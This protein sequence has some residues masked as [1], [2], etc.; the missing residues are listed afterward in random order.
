MKFSTWKASKAASNSSKDRA[1]SSIES[2][3]DPPTGNNSKNCLG[4]RK[5]STKAQSR[6]DLRQFTIIIIV[7]QSATNGILQFQASASLPLA[8]SQFRT[9]SLEKHLASWCSSQWHNLQS[10]GF[11][12]AEDSNHDPRIAR[13]PSQPFGLAKGARTNEQEDIRWH[14]CSNFQQYSLDLR[15]Q[16]LQYLA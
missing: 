7:S 1:V 3:S 12:F 11:T 16:Y 8:K 9:A 2:Y 4:W 6:N 10:R 5:S 13:V 15:S 14:L